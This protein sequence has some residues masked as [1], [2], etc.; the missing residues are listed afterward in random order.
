[1]VVYDQL[2]RKD[3]TPSK[4]A[5]FD[6]IETIVEFMFK[7]EHEQETK[8]KRKL[9]KDSKRGL[10][11]APTTS[12]KEAF[13][14][15]RQGDGLANDAPNHH[16]NRMRWRRRNRP[17]CDAAASAVAPRVP[18]RAGLPGSGGTA[19]PP[20]LTTEQQPSSMVECLLTVSLSMQ[21]G[22][23]DRMSVCADVIF[24]EKK[25]ARMWFFA[26]MWF[27]L[28]TR[29]VYDFLYTKEKRKRGARERQ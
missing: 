29:F 20:R 28:G 22:K 15:R 17:R 16:H 2:A 8:K 13:N 21:R 11:T 5:T 6:E 14:A 4:S 12:V 26:G 10:S 19:I 3:A 23:V 18:P 9:T 1:M 25:N 7:S 27:F 24:Y